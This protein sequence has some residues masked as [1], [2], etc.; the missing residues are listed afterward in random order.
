LARNP[1]LTGADFRR[2]LFRVATNQ[3]IEHQRKEST[4]RERAETTAD[5]PHPAAGADAAEHDELL[6]KLRA[7]V[8]R[9]ADPYRVV[10]AARLG[11]EPPGETAGRLGI[12]RGTVDKVLSRQ[13]FNPKRNEFTDLVRAD[14]ERITDLSRGGRTA[15]AV[16]LN[17][18]PR[19]PD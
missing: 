13:V 9:L 17:W 12:P 4:R 1:G 16:Q 18:K 14:S 7:C 8:D 3:M 5:L 2:W 10:V 19:A 11:G 15:V 6:A